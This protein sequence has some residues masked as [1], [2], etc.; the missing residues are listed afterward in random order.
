MSE[1][2]LAANVMH[3]A[4]LLRR[5]G[6]PVGP[7]EAIAAQHALTR[8]DLGNRTEARTALRTTSS[9]VEVSSKVSVIKSPWLGASCPLITVASNSI[10]RRGLEKM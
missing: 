10:F 7:S 5:A 6:L 2:A 9:S 3:F 1:T 8:I 4:R